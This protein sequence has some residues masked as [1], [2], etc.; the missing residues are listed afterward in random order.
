VNALA[1]PAHVIQRYPRAVDAASAA[2]LYGALLCASAFAPADYHWQLTFPYAVLAA[3]ACGAS[4]FRHDRPGFALT[5]AS[6]AVILCSLL[7]INHGL[8]PV[9]VLLPLVTIFLHADR[10]EAMAIAGCAVLAITAAAVVNNVIDRSEP[11]GVP[12]GFSVL[13]LGIMGIAI[14]E[15]RRNRRDYV[16]EAEERVRRAEQEREH[17]ARR[18]VA[19][20]RLRISRDLHDI[21]AHHI[22]LITVQA[23]AAEHLLETRPGLAREALGHIHRAGEEALADL[24]GTIA[25][26]RTPEEPAAPT[27]PAGGLARLDDLAGA[28]TRSGL[29]IGVERRGDP[30]CLPA[31]V[32]LAA[33]RIVQEALTNVRKHAGPVAVSVLIEY[34]EPG[35][36]VTIRNAPADGTAASAAGGAAKGA[37][38][39][40][41]G[42]GLVGMRERAAALGARLDAGALPGGGY[43]VTAAF[44]LPPAVLPDRSDHP[45]R[46]GAGR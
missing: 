42:H 5:A 30:R 17:E 46:A 7:R 23:G 2:L 22:A 27:E 34:V 4:V 35:L 31:A 3:V 24:R 36:L 26:L 40:G 6:V 29:R 8:L 32:D 37:A 15:A 21:V 13:I 19:E 43:L 41:T 33:F 12:P 25:L 9:A 10:R 38:A 16:R 45:D 39:D 1:R 28:F 44:P 14:G 20:D 11:Q 18:R